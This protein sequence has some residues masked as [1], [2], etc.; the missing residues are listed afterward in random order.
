[1]RMKERFVERSFRR[2]KV[3][4][5]M[6]ILKIKRTSTVTALPLQLKHF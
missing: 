3:E 5:T 2:K 1:M 6:G 4:G